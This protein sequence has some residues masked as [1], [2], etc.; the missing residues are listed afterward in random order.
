MNLSDR[1]IEVFKALC[2]GKSNKEIAIVLNVTEKTIKFHMTKIFKQIGVKRRS[3]AISRAYAGELPNWIQEKVVSIPKR[4]ENLP[5]PAHVPPVEEP[6]ANPL[7]AG[8][9]FALWE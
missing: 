8:V 3:E 4:E 7:P 1:Q 9:G 2:E 5:L 6:K